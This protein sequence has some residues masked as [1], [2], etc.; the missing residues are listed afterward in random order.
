MTNIIGRINFQMVEEYLE[1]LI[2]KAD[3]SKAHLKSSFY[4]KQAQS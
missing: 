4:N 3:E 2:Y 1:K